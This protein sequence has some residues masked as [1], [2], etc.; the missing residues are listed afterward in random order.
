MWGS[1]P[2]KGLKNCFLFFHSI[3]THRT[4]LIYFH[5]KEKQQNLM[6]DLSEK[7]SDDECNKIKTFIDTAQLL[8]HERTK[9]QQQRKFESLVQE[10]MKIISNSTSPTLQNKNKWVKNLS[11]RTLSESEV[12]LLCKGFTFAVSEEKVPIV[13]MI[14]ATE[15]A[16]VDANLIQGEA[17]TLRSKIC[18]ILCSN[19]PPTIEY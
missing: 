5:L 9:I 19:K 13:E 14:T 1:T 11:D 3:Y 17:E 7:L 16:I 8:Q 4:H 12:S 18:N 2:A 15:R 6:D 10:K